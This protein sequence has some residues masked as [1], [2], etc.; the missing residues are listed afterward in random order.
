MID[1]IQRRMIGHA[2]LIL[3]IGMLAGFGLLVSLIGGIE[4]IPGTVIPISIFGGTDAWVRAHTGGILNALLILGVALALP[5]LRF[6]VQAAGR[7][8]WMIVGT[9]WANTLFY[10]AALLAPNRALSFASNRFGHSSFLSAIGLGPA[11]LF[12][13]ISL[14]AVGLLVHQAF[15]PRP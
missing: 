8:K 10:W 7:I 3:F 6:Q 5:L 4:L 12:V 1:H 11:L 14:F 15:G 2:A 13:F 9:G